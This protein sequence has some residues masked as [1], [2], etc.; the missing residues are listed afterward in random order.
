MPARWTVIQHAREKFSCRSGSVRNALM[1]DAS[2]S[3]SAKAD[4]TR[5]GEGRTRFDGF[6][7]KILSGNGRTGRSIRSIRWYFS[8]R[9]KAPS[10]VKQ[11]PNPGE[12]HLDRVKLQSLT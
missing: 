9:M 4:G 8:A 12:G 10:V 2:R 11:P 1:N 7:D 3:S 6:N 5:G